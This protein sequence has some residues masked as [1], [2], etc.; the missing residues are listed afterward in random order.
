MTAWSKDDKQRLAGTGGRVIGHARNPENRHRKHHV[1]R[2][3]HVATIGALLLV[4]M[5]Q[6]FYFEHVTVCSELIALAFYFVQVTVCSECLNRMMSVE[7]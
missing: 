5:A 6:A 7:V 1:N 3:A 2:S 4:P